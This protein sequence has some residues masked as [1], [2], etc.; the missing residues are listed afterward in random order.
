MVRVV[1]LDE[2]AG[3]A[4]FLTEAERERAEGMTNDILRARF[5]VSRGLRRRVLAECAGRGAA[6]LVFAEE[7]EGKPRLVDGD[8]WDFNLS[9]AGDYVAVAVARGAVGIDL[10]MMREVREM[11]ALVRRYFHA[12]EVRAWEELE[13]EQKEEG[14]FALWSAREA[15]MKCC[16]LGLAGGL[17]VTRVDPGFL[18]APAGRAVVGAEVVSLERLEAPAGY[19]LV[20]ARGEGVTGDG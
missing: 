20:V 19:V 13:V 12:D 9:H 6:D 15:A 16:G 8:G 14:F 11:H 5:V 17:A 2:V 1:G 18:R 10:E 7:G 4:E 3:W